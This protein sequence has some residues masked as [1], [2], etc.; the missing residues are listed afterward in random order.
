[1]ATTLESVTRFAV[2]SI[3]IKTLLSR[4]AKQWVCPSKNNAKYVKG[5]YKQKVLERP[6]AQFFPCG[7]EIPRKNKRGKLKY[8]CQTC[9][10]KSGWIW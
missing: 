7:K 9:A 10:R 8:R 1:M 5:P 2:E 3:P 4:S 6:S